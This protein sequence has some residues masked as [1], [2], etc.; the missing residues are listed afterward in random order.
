MKEKGAEHGARDASQ[1]EHGHGSDEDEYLQSD[2]RAV[3]LDHLRRLGLD[4]Y[5]ASDRDVEEG[6]YYSYYFTSMPRIVTSVC[7][8]KVNN[9][10]FDCINLL[11]RG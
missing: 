7:C 11:V 3:L 4:A 9:M 10:N 2:I 8:I 1:H 6:P 5:I